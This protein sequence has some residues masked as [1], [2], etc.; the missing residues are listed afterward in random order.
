MS[1][2]ISGT[3]PGPDLSRPSFLHPS[4]LDFALKLPA[5]V[6]WIWNETVRALADAAD[7]YAAL[8]R[9]LSQAHSPLDA[10]MELGRYYQ[11]STSKQLARI[12]AYFSFAKP[13]E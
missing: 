1:S 10:S 6:P 7:D 4:Y 11:T 8:L 2:K 9:Q 12:A 13:A 5:S 3:A